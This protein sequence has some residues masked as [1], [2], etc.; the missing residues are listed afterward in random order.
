[1]PPIVVAG[2]LAGAGMVAGGIISSAGQAKANAANIEQAGKQ[3]SF[4]EE[5]SNTAVQRRVADLRAAGINPILAAKESA[6]TPTGAM[7]RV[8]NELA[9]VG[10]GVSSASG[11]PLQGALLG[12]QINL[13]S[14]QAE[15][16]ESNIAVNKSS[17]ALN[18]A[19]AEKALADAGYTTQ[20]ARSAKVDA[21]VAETG[22]PMRGTMSWTNQLIRSLTGRNV[23]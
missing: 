10:E 13:Q 18:K 12:S 19:L 8:E 5:M 6:S 1:M 11:V 22:A 3:M 23:R 9:G 4:E 2:A 14:A 7:A 16:A 15:Q 20:N 17:V 21:D